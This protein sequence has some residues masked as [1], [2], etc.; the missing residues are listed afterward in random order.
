MTVKEN[1]HHLIDE[2]NDV[3]LLEDY[4]EL[5]QRLKNNVPGKLWTKLNEIQQHELLSAY[6]ESFNPD[7][8]IS[9]EAVKKQHEQWLK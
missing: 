9:H 1:L 7:N 2:I 6:E 4:Y 8:L 3:Q 5:I